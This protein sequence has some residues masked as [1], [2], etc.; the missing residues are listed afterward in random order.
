MRRRLLAAACGLW[1]L[2]SGC[3]PGLFGSGGGQGS[4][5]RVLTVY[6]LA[7]DGTGGELTGRELCPLPEDAGSEVRAAVELFASPS[8]AEGLTCALPEGVTVEDWSLDNGAVTLTLSEGFLQASP[9]DRTAAALCATLTLCGL[10][11]VKSVNVAA[12]GQTLFSGLVPADALLR[13]TDQDPSVRQLR[14]YFA[15]SAGRYLTS[16]YHS[17]T[18]AED[19]AADRYVMEELLRGPNSPELSAAVPA[20]T[21]LLSCR[22]R[23]GVCTVDLSA[24]F[25]EDR[26][27]TALGERLALYSIVNSLTSLPQVDSVRLLVEGQPVDRYVYRSLA[28]PLVRNGRAVMAA[29]T[30]PDTADVDLY[31]PLPGLEAIGPLP[32]QVALE[33]YASLPEA[34]LA[35]L[36]SAAEP[37]YPTVFPGGAGGAVTVSEG[38]CSVALPESFFASVPR[39]ALPAAIQSVAA[40]LQALGGVDQVRFTLDG[41]PAVFEGTDWSGPWKRFDLME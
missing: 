22:T 33:G 21:R 30:G 28:E 18:L 24:A 6:R 12:G 19:A 2:L 17:L 5:D 14:L 27:D 23:D 32:W 26:P 16:E 11:G 40:T 9:M 20:G 36:M 13:D 1:L 8:A 15:D 38:V 37:G 34:V 7:E 29:G 4:Q 3:A 31:L 35:A 41:G 25:Y 39:Q 10:E